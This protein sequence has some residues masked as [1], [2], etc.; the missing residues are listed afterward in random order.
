MRQK[1][2]I[3]NWKMNG[4]KVHLSGLLDKF[5]TGILNPEA[6]VVCPPFIYMPLAEERL[7]DSTILLGAQDVSPHAEGAHT[8]DVAISMLQ[9]FG[10][11]YVIVGHSERRNYQAETDQLVADKFAAVIAGGLTPVLCVGETLEEHERGQ[12]NAVVLRQLDAIIEKAGV[13]AFGQAVVAYEPVWAIGTGKTATP[14]QAQQVHAL[15]RSRIAQLNGTVAVGLKIL[16][17]GSVKAANAQALFTMPDI[18]GGLVG[19]A[20]LDAEEFTT[21]CNAAG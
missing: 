7:S 19:G 15:I 10:C 6:V 11:T 18:D 1:L 2:V 3:A 13:E 21:I 5:A 9:E 20:S 8:G 17:G 12:T 14:S 16:Y 4:G